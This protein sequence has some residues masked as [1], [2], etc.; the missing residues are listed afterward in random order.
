MTRR[1]DEEWVSALGKD[2]SAE[3]AAAIQDL[4]R[5]LYRVVY[6]YLLTRQDI[7]KLRDWPETE[8]ANQAFDFVHESLRQILRKLDSY[9]QRGHF[10][11]WAAAVAKNK[12]KAELRKV[13]WHREE[14]APYSDDRSVD[15]TDFWDRIA[16]A[17]DGLCP[18]QTAEFNR[19]VDYIRMG[20]G[21]SL[22][23]DQRKAFEDRFFKGKTYREIASELGKTVNRVYLLIYEARTRLK[24]VMDGL[25]LTLGEVY[26]IFEKGE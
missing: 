22:T 4:G 7:P 19:V 24:L 13:K 11:S 5:Y 18:Q 21:Q 6:N 25:G 12:A 16:R 26:A 3:Q 8:M 10:L 15:G 9:A 1:T 2:G 23:E 14:R 17:G 20:I